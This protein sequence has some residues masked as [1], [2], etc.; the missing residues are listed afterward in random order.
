MTTGWVFSKKIVFEIITTNRSS[1]NE[2]VRTNGMDLKM[3]KKINFKSKSIHLTSTH[4]LVHEKTLSP[5]ETHSW[6]INDELVSLERWRFS[7]WRT[8]CAIII[9]RTI[10]TTL[11]SAGLHSNEMHKAV[12]DFLFGRTNKSISAATFLVKP[13]EYHHHLINDGCFFR[14]STQ[15]NWFTKKNTPQSK[16]HFQFLTFVLSVTIRAFRS[17]EPRFSESRERYKWIM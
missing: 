16:I 10:E 14:I 12:Y 3:K 5:L 15:T 11:L 2:T 9:A 7:C 17:I 13:L 4:R 8:N 6:K 1:I